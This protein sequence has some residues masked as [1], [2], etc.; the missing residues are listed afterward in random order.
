[1][2]QEHW[3]PQDELDRIMEQYDKDGNGVIDFEE[4]KQIV[5][6]ALSHQFCGHASW[7]RLCVHTYLCG[8]HQQH[9]CYEHVVRA[10]LSILGTLQCTGSHSPC[11]AQSS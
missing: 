11:T 9:G 10:S 3:L 5:S 6:A 1:M 4:F 2:L 7:L 8:G